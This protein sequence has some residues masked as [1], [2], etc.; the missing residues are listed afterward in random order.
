MQEQLPVMYGATAGVQGEG[1]A[2]MQYK[3]AATKHCSE[4]LGPLTLMATFY[5]FN[6]GL[7]QG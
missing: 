3:P 2:A 1:T 7:R 4:A 6:S 5:F